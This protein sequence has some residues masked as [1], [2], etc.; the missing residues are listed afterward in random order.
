MDPDFFRYQLI[1]YF[2]VSLDLTYSDITTRVVRSAHYIK[3]IIP[4]LKK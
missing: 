2:S 1:R 3:R 4:S